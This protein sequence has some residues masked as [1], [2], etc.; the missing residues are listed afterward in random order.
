[1][2]ITVITTTQT[3]NINVACKL[4]QDRSIQILVSYEASEGEVIR[5][6]SGKP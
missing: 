6:F 2:I 4:C 3:K 1:M 5:Q